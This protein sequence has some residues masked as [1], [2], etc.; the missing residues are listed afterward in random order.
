MALFSAR[1]LSSSATIRC[2][3]DFTFSVNSSSFIGEEYHQG[4]GQERRKTVKR[5][6]G[7]VKREDVK[8]EDVK[9][10]D[11]KREEGGRDMRKTVRCEVLPPLRPQT[12]LGAMTCVEQLLRALRENPAAWDD[13]KL[14]ELPRLRQLAAAAE[15]HLLLLRKGHL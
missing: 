12:V 13:V 10:E 2:S 5:K 11:V 9:R 15:T 6:E 1:T 4:P 3:Q 7:N 14:S 8:R